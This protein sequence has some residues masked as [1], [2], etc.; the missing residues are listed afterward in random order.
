[1]QARRA[2]A[3]VSENGSLTVNKLPFPA[4]EPVEVVVLPARNQRSAEDRYPL[5]GTPIQFDDPTVPVGES[6]WEVLR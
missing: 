6:D 4:G 5:R 3:I 1:M 2:K